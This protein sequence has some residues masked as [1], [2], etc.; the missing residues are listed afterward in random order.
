MVKQI[1]VIEP[2]ERYEVLPS[3]KLASKVKGYDLDVFAD[4]SKRFLNADAAITISDMIDIDDEKAN[5]LANAR[6]QAMELAAYCNE[7]IKQIDDVVKAE[8]NEDNLVI[9]APRYGVEFALSVPRV[10]VTY[11]KDAIK[12]EQ[13][14]VWRKV[15]KRAG[16][17]M[18]KEER[19]ELE[20][21]IKQKEAELKALNM[22]LAQDNAAKQ[23]VFSE[24]M[25]DAMIEANPELTK[26]RHEERHSS[27]YY[28]RN[29]K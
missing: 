23:V 18:S 7:A 5:K 9:M 16:I 26:Y 13:P 15:A 6:I 14:K 29:S 21:Q 1:T 19:D 20:Q 28:F 22:E 2:Q 3:A 12:A 11:D 24:D 4:L 8:L 17:P 27:R 10:T 25:F